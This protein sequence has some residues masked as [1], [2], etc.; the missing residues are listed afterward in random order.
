VIHTKGADQS[1]SGKITLDALG[2]NVFENL[3]V[4][5]VNGREWS[6]FYV[7]ALVNGTNQTIEGFPV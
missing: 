3:N 1:S 7:E 5:F 4:N 2:D 6:T